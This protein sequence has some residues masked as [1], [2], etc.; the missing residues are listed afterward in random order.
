MSSDSGF[1]SLTVCEWVMR[2]NGTLN[3]R[4]LAITLRSFHLICNKLLCIIIIILTAVS[5]MIIVLI[6]RTVAIYSRAAHS[7]GRLTGYK[8][9]RKSE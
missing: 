6:M 4:C 9:T 5:L 3:C 8:D 1:S 2:K 7:I